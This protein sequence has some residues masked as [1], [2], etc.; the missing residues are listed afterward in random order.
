MRKAALRSALSGRL[1]E[2][3]LIVV[4]DF[5]LEEIKTKGLLAV[6]NRFDL[7]N[8]LLVDDSSNINLKKSAKNLKKFKFIATEGLNVY[9][10]LKFDAVVVTRSSV[11]KIEGALKK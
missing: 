9:D 7:S 6:L 11:E 5:Q 2:A 10:L 8:A 3:Q 1:Q 4:E